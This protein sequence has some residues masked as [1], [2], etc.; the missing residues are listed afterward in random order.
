MP[1]NLK[2][3]LLYMCTWCQSKHFHNSQ[4][5][6]NNNCKNPC[7]TTFSGSFSRDF[8]Q[9]NSSSV[10]QTYNTVEICFVLS[11]LLLKAQYHLLSDVSLRVHELFQVCRICIKGVTFHNMPQYVLFMVL[12]YNQNLCNYHR[13]FNLHKVVKII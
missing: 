2:Q 1:D 5:E 10:T 3:A 12:L 7:G 11:P 4:N 9:P 8:Q 13:I 6:N